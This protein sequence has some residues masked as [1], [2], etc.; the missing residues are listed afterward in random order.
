MEEEGQLVKVRARGLEKELGLGMMT[1][2]EVQPFSKVELS[3]TEV[4][5]KK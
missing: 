3:I 1:V 2:A 4:E 5:V